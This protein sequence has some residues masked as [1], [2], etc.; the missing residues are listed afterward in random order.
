MRLAFNRDA[1]G[2]GMLV[3]VDQVVIEHI[4]D[5]GQDDLVL[6]TL[7]SRKRGHHRC[8]IQFQRV[9][10]NRVRHIGISPKALFLGIS[11]HQGDLILITAGQAQ[12]F[13]GLF[14]NAKEATG[15]AIFGRHIG[16]CRTV[17]KRQGRKA[18]AIIFYKAANH[19]LGA[20]HLRC[21]QHKVGRGHALG[22]CTGQ[23]EADNFRDEH[24][25]R[26]AQHRGLRLNPANAPS[27]DA[28]AVDHR[29]VAVCTHASVGICDG[30]AVRSCAG[31]NRLRNMLQID[32]MANARAGRDRLEIVQRLGT[33]FQ[34]VI[35]FGI[36]LIFDF[37]I[38]FRRLGMAEFV[39]HDAVV[40]DQMHRDQRV[41][42][43]R[44]GFQR[45]HGIA[46]RSEVNYA[47]HAGKILQQNA[48]RAILNFALRLGVLLPIDQRLHILH[49]NGKAA[50]FK[51]EQVFE[52][53][54]HRKRQARHIA[55]FL[56][57][58]FDREI[59]HR[60]AASGQGGAG[61]QAV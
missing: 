59:I 61:L 33:P 45:G 54:L 29:R 18:G 12:I 17:G 34:K 44:V 53:H 42:L 35:A 19:A 28:K 39:D 14:I 24:R 2:A 13:D 38:L 41:D 16:Q 10:E 11:F 56:R 52:Q 40:D 4:V 20:Q 21:G 37:D 8:H 57:N 47:R 7:W 6:R 43:R 1:L 36:A 25:H 15:R 27:K 22:Q 5:L 26:L 60:L 31:P 46:H 49:R 3:H 48:G 30:R 50:I 58:L 55:Q 23:L 32:L 51:T 9:G